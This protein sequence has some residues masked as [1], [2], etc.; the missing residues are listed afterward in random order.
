MQYHPLPHTKTVFGKI[1]FSNF[2]PYP[3]FCKSSSGSS[4]SSG[5]GSSSRSIV[6]C[7]SLLHLGTQPKTT[8]RTDREPTI[9]EDFPGL[10]K[11]PND[12]I[13]MRAYLSTVQETSKKCNEDIMH[14]KSFQSDEHFMLYYKENIGTSISYFLGPI[15]RLEM[16]NLNYN[17][18]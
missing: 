7:L 13:R 14:P 10:P 8:M 16:L 18:A 1:T 12:I 11:T 9:F 4:S 17:H 6:T 5:G 2:T 3:N 15:L